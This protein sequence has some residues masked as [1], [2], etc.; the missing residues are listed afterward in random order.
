MENLL[1][2]E[3][4]KN[5]TLQK[6]GLGHVLKVMRDIENLLL[7]ELL[8]NVTFHENGYGTRSEGYARH[9]KPPPGGASKKSHFPR[10]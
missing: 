1:L 3:L 6:T 2:E 10:K 7:E 4:L 5:V 9:G 8:K